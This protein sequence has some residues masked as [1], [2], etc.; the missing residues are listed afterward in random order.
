[1]PIPSEPATQRRDV[2]HL[3]RS[4]GRLARRCIRPSPSERGDIAGWVMITVM[5][6][7]LAGAIMAIFTPAVTDYLQSALDQFM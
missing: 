3:G 4:R 2:L 5:T 7:M 6:I 1:M